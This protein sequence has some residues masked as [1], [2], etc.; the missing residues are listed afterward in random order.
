MTR[1]DYAPID[2]VVVVDRHRANLGDLHRLADS[3]RETGLL[4]AIVVTPDMRLIAGHRRLEACRL[5]GMDEVPVRVVSNLTSAR[6]L[7]FAERDENTCRLDMTPGE[8][9]SLGLALEELERPKAQ[10]R[11]RNL[12]TD[13]TKESFLSSDTQGE[14]TGQTRDLV[15][16]AVGMSGRTFVRAKA[17][18]AAANGHLV[19]G[20]PVSAEVQEVAVKALDEMNTTGKVNS[21]YE[22]VVEAVKVGAEPAKLRKT[23]EAVGGRV[24]TARR[25][26]AEGHTSDQIGATIGV[27]H[28]ANFKRIH[29]L[30]VPADAVVGRRRNLDSNR[31]VGATVAAVTGVDSLFDAIDYSALDRAELDHWISS[32][33]DAIRSLTTLRNNLRKELTQ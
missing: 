21:A 13:T 32:L 23:R 20:E 4:H 1:G 30:E 9:V 27:D 18:V 26:A 14:R 3:I 15:G 11:M 17:V 29:G 2:N 8:K 7:L 12:P 10:E 5:L 22:K 31:I 16:E 24:E 6:S 33:S 25:M 28:M 19:N